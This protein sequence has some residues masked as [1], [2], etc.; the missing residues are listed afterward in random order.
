MSEDTDEP[1]DSLDEDYPVPAPDPHP[2]NGVDPESNTAE[3]DLCGGRVS[4][5]KAVPNKR[6]EP[7]HRRC[8]ADA[9]GGPAWLR[10][11]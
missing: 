4:F 9:Y 8:Y 3:C 2:S 10:D 6:E 5:S 11:G 7:V 1:D